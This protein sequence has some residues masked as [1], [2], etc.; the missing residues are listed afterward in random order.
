MTLKKKIELL[1]PLVA[2][3]LTNSGNL[4]VLDSKGNFIEYELE[5]YS[6]V[7]RFETD[8]QS[9]VWN[10]AIA[11]SYD[12]NFLLIGVE[13][14]IKVFSIPEKK[15]LYEITHEG[16]IISASVDEQ[17]RYFV[18]TSD[19]G[20]AFL[21]NLNSGQSLFS[22]PKHDLAI[23]SSAFNKSGNIVATGTDDGYINL[24]NIST[25][26]SMR[27]IEGDTSIR[28]LKFLSENYLLSVD[29]NNILNLW[30]FSDGE[31]I[32]TLLE[33]RSNITKLEISPDEKF[34][35]VG[36]TKGKVVL[37][38]LIEHKTISNKHAVIENKITNITIVNEN[39]D[40]ALSDDKGNIFIYSAHEDQKKLAGLIKSKKYKEAYLLVEKNDILKYT[41][42]YEVLEMI[43]EATLKKSE[44]FLESEMRDSKKAELMLQP[45]AVDPKKR[46][47]IDE[48]VADFK[49]YAK[50]TQFVKSQNYNLAY[51]IVRKHPSLEK[52]KSYRKLEAIWQ[53]YFKRAKL[54]LFETGGEAKA[55]EILSKF[56]GISEKAFTIKNLF[57]QKNVYLQFQNFLKKRRYNE[58]LNLV[59]KNKFLETNSDFQAVLDKLDSIFIEMKLAV[60]N[61]KLDT[62]LEHA[63]FLSKID[64]FKKEAFETLEELDNHKKFREI[65]SRGDISEMLGFSEGKPYLQKYPE[66]AR[67]NKKWDK[68]VFE[69][70]EFA[71]HGDI[72][73][74]LNSISE[75]ISVQVRHKKMANIFKIAYLSDLQNTIN[76]NSDS[77]EIVFPLLSR[78]IT[79]YVESFGIDQEIEDLI[80]KIE[81][82][83]DK[84]VDRDKFKIGNID[85]WK[86]EMVKSSILE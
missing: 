53:D 69:A 38:D 26:K 62:A 28:L 21:W 20:R 36:T 23:K 51:D 49:E 55:K 19:D 79:N 65:L 80:D 17:N 43:W 1:N 11:V 46:E 12:D 25:M 6:E 77:L 81:K 15:F 3:D 41:K 61:N 85:N 73:N 10:R 45:F 30:R 50:L 59:H 74:V 63:E 33:T 35:F 31:K 37:Y 29:K 4:F 9:S 7:T 18:S 86:P 48:M 71:S 44:E 16:T 57:L 47:I 52:T 24:V 54:Q 13:Q 67:L 32:K 22:F 68:V 64:D 27:S 66:I 82:K 75:F 84:I 56:A 72:D 78:G 83:S 2:M 76:D 14:N 40:F 34:L 5:N 60:R 58:L 42:E 70:Q 39:N 8:I